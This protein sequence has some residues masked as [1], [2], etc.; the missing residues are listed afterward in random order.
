MSDKCAEKQDYWK[1]HKPWLRLMVQR[2]LTV[3]AAAALAHLSEDHA[4][5]VI[6]IPR[7]QKYLAS[8]QKWHADRALQARID[9]GLID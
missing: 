1:R 7:V 8:L 9:A 4:H 3:R 5:R 2:G 6:K